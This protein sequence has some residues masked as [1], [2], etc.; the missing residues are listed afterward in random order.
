MD[1]RKMTISEKELYGPKTPFSQ[2]IH[3]TRHRGPEETYDDYTVRYCRAVAHDDNRQF[4][5]TLHHTRHQSI[6]PAGR[7]QVSVGRPFATTAF[8]CFVSQDIEDSLQG[9]FDTLR[10]AAITMGAGGGIGFDFSTIRPQGELVRGLGGMGHAAGPIEFMRPFSEMCKVLVR[11]WARGAMMGVLRVDHPDIL[12]FINAKRNQDALNAFNISVAVSDKFMEAL[13]HD[14]L[15]ELQFQGQKMG[16]A[17]AWDIWGPIMEANWDWAEPGVIFMDRI[18]QLNPLY[19]CERI[20]ATNPCAEQP[21]PANGCCLLGS[22]NM[23]KFLVPYTQQ[24]PTLDES[25]PNTARLHAIYGGHSITRYDI[26][27]DLFDEAIEMSVR[28]YDNVIDRTIYPLREQEEEEKAKR[29]MGIGPTGMANCLE[30]MGLPYGSREYIAMQD[31]ILNRAANVAYRTS[32]R[33]AKEKGPF[34]LW[35]VE[36]YCEGAFFNRLDEDVQDLIVHNGLRNGLLT[37]IAPTGTISLDAD[38]VSGGIEPV[39]S[40]ETE[41][42]VDTVTHGIQKFVLQDYAYNFYD[43]RG[44]RADEIAPEEHINVLCHAQKWIDSSISKTCNVKGQQGGQGPGTSFKDFE[45]LYMQAWEGGAKSCTTYN[46]NGK[47]GGVLKSVDTESKAETARGEFNEDEG[48]ACFIDP[49]TGVRSCE[50]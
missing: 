11:S 4:Y 41:R 34:K 37:S 29:R 8:N 36:K 22:Y 3:S 46:I 23:V 13:I 15:V 35:D 5:R 25:N 43:I 6:L 39:F 17:R 38:N 50:A 27:W 9:I 7:Q 33:L 1:G 32:A 16:Q 28:A 45:Q 40:Y 31:C 2:W 12:R 21:L 44:R 14:G 24:L 26:D 49:S 19:Y 20:G 10:R 47:R 18:N 48:L 30:I 42:T